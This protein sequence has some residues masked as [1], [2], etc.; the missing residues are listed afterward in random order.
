MST[1]TDGVSNGHRHPGLHPPGYRE[2]SI[3]SNRKCGRAANG[4]VF[5][6]NRFRDRAYYDRTDTSPPRTCTLR[7]SGASECQAVSIRAALR[8]GAGSKVARQRRGSERC[9]AGQGKASMDPRAV[10]TRAIRHGGLGCANLRISRFEV[11][12]AGTMV[13]PRGR[14]AP[15]RRGEEARGHESSG[16]TPA[17]KSDSACW[18]TDAVGTADDNVG[19][20]TVHP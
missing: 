12:S 13:V 9:S 3:A 4:A 14:N 8:P 17:L 5:Y 16:A 15:L 6:R 7:P 2:G 1:V 19:P 20:V 11:P 10:H 18:S